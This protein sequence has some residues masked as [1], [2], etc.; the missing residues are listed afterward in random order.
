[1]G[2]G[3]SKEVL[4]E[5]LDEESFMAVSKI[6][7]SDIFHKKK[8]KDGHL[9]KEQVLD[10]LKALSLFT[11]GDFPSANF[12]RESPPVRSSETEVLKAKDFKVQRSYYIP[13]Y[14]LSAYRNIQP[15]RSSKTCLT[16]Q[17]FQKT[18]SGSF[19]YK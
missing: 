2:S 14:I 8:D 13:S 1:M 3:I 6:M 4:P 12:E 17:M 5:R 9:T 11:T 15:I 18:F 7:L 16:K 19:P 10:F